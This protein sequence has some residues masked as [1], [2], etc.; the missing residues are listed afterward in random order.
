MQPILDSDEPDARPILNLPK[1]REELADYSK[2]IKMSF[3]PR[4]ILLFFMSVILLLGLFYLGIELNNIA[5]TFLLTLSAAFFIP[6][7]IGLIVLVSFMFIYIGILRETW[8]MWQDLLSTKVIIYESS[9]IEKLFD[10]S[11][12]TPHQVVLRHVIDKRQTFRIAPVDF[13]R[14]HVGSKVHI[15]L[16]FH[17]KLLLA[18]RV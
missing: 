1:E 9:I 7:L 17:A 2:L 16:S 13:N 18:L 10:E 14:C 15:V 4:L 3:R 11:S 5:F 6:L 12:D 8:Q